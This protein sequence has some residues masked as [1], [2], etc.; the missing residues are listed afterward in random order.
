M[1]IYIFSKKKFEIKVRNDKKFIDKLNF[2]KINDYDN[3]DIFIKDH[4]GSLNLSS[5][6]IMSGVPSLNYKSYLHNNIMFLEIISTNLQSIILKK[7]IKDYTIYILQN[8]LIVLY[9]ENFY[10]YYFNY[11][12]NI[13]V[14]E[15]NNILYI[16][17]KINLIIFDSINKTFCYLKCIKYEENEQIFNILCTFNENS[18]YFLSFIFN[19]TS[20]EIIISKHKKNHLYLKNPSQI[21]NDFFYLIKL[22]FSYAKNLID[23]NIDFNQIKQYLLPFHSILKFEN[24]YYIFTKNDVRLI[25][26]KTE[27][28]KIIY[29]D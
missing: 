12:D 2:I 7:L 4:Y 27:N 17:N 1:D 11:K 3:S 22:D 29:I 20:K 5:L 9:K 28:G 13:Q 19:K 18:N 21:I 16:F 15:K 6:Q 14:Y 23:K 24:E 8:N 25:K 10:S 26:F